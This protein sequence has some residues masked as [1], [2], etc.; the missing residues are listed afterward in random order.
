[1]FKASYITRSLVLGTQIVMTPF[2]MALY[3]IKP[4]AMHRFVGYLEETACHT[5]V[6]IIENVQTPG[7]NLNLA[8]KD[9]PAP[10]IA[11]GY[12]KLKDDAMFVD[13]LMCMV[14]VVSI[15]AMI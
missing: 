4:S 8:W 15:F 5:Y 3:M 6:S 2:L 10:S 14:R 11:K 9:I 7:T 1:M 13:V 12:W